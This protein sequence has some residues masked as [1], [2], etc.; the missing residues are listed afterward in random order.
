[1]SGYYKP[2]KAVVGDGKKTSVGDGKKN[3]GLH[4]RACSCSWGFTYA[5][6]QT[7]DLNRSKESGADDISANFP[8]LF[9]TSTISKIMYAK[10]MYVRITNVT[11]T[12]VHVYECETF[13]S[14]N[15]IH[16]VWKQKIKC[17]NYNVL[18]AQYILFPPVTKLPEFI[19]PVSSPRI[20]NYCTGPYCKMFR[21]IL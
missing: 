9:T 2:R 14:L 19:K 6:L 8:L 12:F 20:Q 11:F 10:R 5:N 7:K 4:R 15:S 16:H 3:L 18:I 17:Y 21:F 1:M 13:R